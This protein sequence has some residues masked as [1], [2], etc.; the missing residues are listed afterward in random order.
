META[1]DDDDDAA[2]EDATDNFDVEVDAGTKI[3]CIGGA[4]TGSGSVYPD[5][6]GA[7]VAVNVGVNVDVGLDK[8]E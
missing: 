2:V 3:D 8:S 5:D 4:G 1:F 6:V 7:A